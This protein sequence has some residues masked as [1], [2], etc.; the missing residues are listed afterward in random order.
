MSSPLEFLN[1]EDA[2]EADYEMPLRELYSYRDG[3]HWADGFVT[4]VRPGAAT[5]GSALVQFEDRLWVPVSDVRASDH[6]VAVLLNPDDSVYT[7]VVQTLVDGRPVDPIRDI[8]LVDDQNVGTEWRLIA[9]EPTGTRVRYR[10]AGT[11]ELG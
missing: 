1:A 4:G 11:A 3:D 10:Y 9:P 6:Y 5:D 2:D 7:E 8:S